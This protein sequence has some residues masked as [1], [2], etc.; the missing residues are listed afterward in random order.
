MINT[1]GCMV[2][3]LVIK[4]KHGWRFCQIQPIPESILQESNS[5][6]VS[7]ATWLRRYFGSQRN[8]C[9]NTLWFLLS[10]DRCYI[11]LCKVILVRWDLGHNVWWRFFLTSTNVTTFIFID[12]ICCFF[13]NV[14]NSVFTQRHYEHGTWRCEREKTE[15]FVFVGSIYVHTALGSLIWAATRTKLSAWKWSCKFHTNWFER[16]GHR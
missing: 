13:T 1:N 12:E 9:G 15:L 11:E 4:K 7:P 6:L 16:K 3:Q 10:F 14:S 2:A 8:N 5:S